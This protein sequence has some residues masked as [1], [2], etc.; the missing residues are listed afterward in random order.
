M[1]LTKVIF[2]AMKEE[3]ELIIKKYNMQEVKKLANISLFE[4]QRGDAEEKLVLALCGIGK[5]QTAIASSHVFENYDIFKCVNIGIAGNIGWNDLKV[6]DVVLPNTFIQHDAYLPSESKEF[7]YLKAPIFLDYAVWE[8]LDLY[9]FWLAMN[10]ICITGDQ[11]IDDPEKLHSLKENFGECVVDME[12]FSFLSV[13]R[14]FGLLDKC[15]VIKGISDSA[16]EDAKD[17]HMNNLE[18]AMNN[19]IVILDSVL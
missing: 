12:A 5:V 19:S 8:N 14:E 3:A 18:L 9:K 16:D 4:W 17:A 7:D 6:G 13:A 10:G 15:V 11:F 1:Q 2:T